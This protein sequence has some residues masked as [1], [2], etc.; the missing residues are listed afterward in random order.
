MR[1]APQARA[2][3]ELARRRPQLPPGLSPRVRMGPGSLLGPGVGPRVRTVRQARLPTRC[4]MP[5][6]RGVGGAG[7]G[8]VLG[9]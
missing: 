6:Q 3:A 1:A 4:Q 8:Q 5:G 9:Q 7:L 2:R